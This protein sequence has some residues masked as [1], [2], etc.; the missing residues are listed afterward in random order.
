MNKLQLQTKIT[1]G[2]LSGLLLA[3]T[4]DNSNL[5][6]L[7]PIVF[8]LWWGVTHKRSL[9]DYLV[10]SFSFSLVFWAIHIIWIISIG[11]DAYILLT[12]LMTI[13]YGSSGILMYFLRNS[14]L[15]FLG[16]ALVYIAIETLT[17]DYPFGGFPWA[18][19]A[20]AS[21]DSPFAK[22]APYGSTQIVA[23]SIFIVAIFVIPLIGFILQKAVFP[24]LFIGVSI[25]AFVLF[26]DSLSFNFEKTGEKNLLI[27]QGNVPRSGLM[28]NE[29]KLAVLKN[30]VEETKKFFSTKPESLKVDAVLW[31]ENSIDV[32]PYINAEAAKILNDHLKSIDKPFI[33]GAVLTK[34]NNLKNSILKMQNNINNKE[35]EYTKIHLVPF[36]EYLPFRNVLESR[37]SRFNL[38]IKDFVKGSEITNFRLDNDLISPVICFEV[39]W[40]DILSKQIINGGELISVHTNNA[41]YAFSDQI[42]QQFKITRFRALEASRQ[43]VVSATTG[44]SAHIDEFG[45][46]LWKSDEF[47]PVSHLA[48][49]KLITEIT[50]AIRYIDIINITS[51][52]L[53]LLLIVLAV[54]KGRINR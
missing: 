35:D 25:F 14:Y 45:K 53:L 3:L 19:I 29:Q 37:I 5:W 31:P 26:L 50:P 46:V 27:V 47:K 43:T 9:S 2:S 54:L 40:N 30:H 12:L 11:V 49:V 32:D 51:Y 16:Y 38:L 7:I 8:A 36:G 6:F 44:I 34:G 42:E 1:V 15:P 4:Y 33:A 20:Y 23:L 10:I 48:Q 41:T 39:A 21:I 13:I 52:L 24:A 17:Q 18:K 22:L 28:F